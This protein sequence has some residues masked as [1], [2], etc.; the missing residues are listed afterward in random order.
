MKLLLSAIA[1]M[2]GL[3]AVSTQS[4]ADLLS[5]TSSLVA[6]PVSDICNK[7]SAESIAEYQVAS[8]EF[9]REQYKE[10]EAFINNIS[11]T[12]INGIFAKPIL[13]SE[14]EVMFQDLFTK[15]VDLNALGRFVLGRYWKA[16]S[17]NQKQEFIKIFSDLTIKTWARRFNEYAGFS[18]RTTGV[19][20]SK[21]KGQ[22]FVESKIL[23]GPEKEPVVVRWR[24]T[25]KVDGYKIID[26]IVEGSSMARTYRNEYRSVIKNSNNGVQGLIDTLKVKLDELEHPKVNTTASDDKS[27]Q[28][29]THTS[30]S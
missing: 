7:T 8:A 5:S 6:T 3:T 28:A 19:I 15:S 18:V 21:S 23:Q 10:A 16:A 11:N 26:I 27:V 12:A 24:V 22:L 2:A 20:P 1:V 4:N 9:D 14:K 29:N 13:E 30:H 17:N 25:K